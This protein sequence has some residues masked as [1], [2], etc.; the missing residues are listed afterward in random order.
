M[1]YSENDNGRD[2]LPSEVENINKIALNEARP[3]GFVV[4]GKREN[5][6]AIYPLKG[7]RQ[8]TI[9]Q[10]G[11]ASVAWGRIARGYPGIVVSHPKFA[12]SLVVCPS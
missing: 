6:T 4:V 10:A 5:I 7:V 12:R 9:E 11:T 8:D 2:L 1:S 3:K